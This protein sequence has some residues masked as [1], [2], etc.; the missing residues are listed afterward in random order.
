[1]KRPYA[2]PL[3]ALLFALSTV[4]SLPVAVAQPTCGFALGF[5]V[6]H[7]QLPRVVG[8]CVTDAAAQPNGDTLQQTTNGLLVWRKADNWTAFT[9]GSTTWL[10]G[11]QGIQ[12]RPNDQRFPWEQGAASA[13]AGQPAV[14]NGGRAVLA[15]YYPW[16]DPGSFGRAADQPAS[17]PYQS[18]DPALIAR[19]VEQAQGAGID[20]F[21]SAWFGRGDRTDKNFAALLAA[22][23]ARTFHATIY[24]ETDHVLQSGPRAV[25][26]QLGNFYSSYLDNPALVRYQGKPVLFFWRTAALDMGAWAAIRAEVDPNHRALW[27]AEGDQFGQ[28][29]GDTFDGIH[30]YSTAWSGNPAATLQSYGARAHARPG[31]LWVPT[32]MPG[33]DDT[34][35]G[36]AGGFAVDRRG[37][38]YYRAAFEGAIASDPDWAIVITSWNEWLEGSQIEPAAG[39]GTLYLDITREEAARFR[40]G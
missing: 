32:A 29:D 40:G 21:I 38:D 10:N 19:Q 31:K 6:L 35:L 34:R 30:P 4:V 12:S 8:D 18:D 3:I 11:P 20:G 37:G 33:Y 15:F 2:L 17:Q 22:A 1:V 39:Y 36:R 26:G 16:F 9:D 13:L 24:F 25:A 27:I 7:A 5:A 14:A 28:L 23:Q